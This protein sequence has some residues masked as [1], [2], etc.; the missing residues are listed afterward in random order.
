[1]TVNETTFKLHQSIE[2]TSQE[3]NS[4][5][6]FH[7]MIN[8]KSIQSGLIKKIGQRQFVLLTAILSYCDEH[9]EAFPSQ[10]TLSEITGI[11]LKTVNQGVQKLLDTKIDGKYLINRELLDSNTVGKFSR[12]VVDFD[13]EVSQ[14][15][16]VEKSTA[17]R[18]IKTPEEVIQQLKEKQVQKGLSHTDLVNYF[19][20]LYELKYGGTY[21]V[22]YTMD[23]PLVKN[24][25]MKS[26]TDKAIMEMFEYIID[27]YE[28]HWY[29]S[30]FKYPTLRGVIS[31]IGNDAIQKMKQEQAYIQEKEHCQTVSYDDDLSLL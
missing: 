12:Y 30:K 6:Q 15:S 22:N 4:L 10:R 13:V 7:V 3:Q 18:Q 28:R 24:K 21:V 31:W 20:A 1:M 5:E 26:M 23:S 8:A 14:E 25:F 9:G 27:N 11:S 17:I 2:A 16:T 29:T 19:K